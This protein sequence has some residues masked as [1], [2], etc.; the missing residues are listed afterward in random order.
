MIPPVF[1]PKEDESVTRF[2]SDD[3]KPG[4]GFWTPVVRFPHDIPGD[5]F[6]ILCL[7]DS[8]WSRYAGLI[9]EWVGEHEDW[10]VLLFC[11]NGVPESNIPIPAEP[12]VELV[13]PNASQITRAL[14]RLSKILQQQREL[15]T[16]ELLLRKQSRNLWILHEVGKALGAEHDLHH[17]LDLILTHARRITGADAGSIYILRVETPNGITSDPQ[18]E[19]K[20][21][22]FF[23]HTQSDTLDLPHRGANIEVNPNSMSGFVAL[24]GQVLNIPD[25]Y[26]LPPDTPYKHNRAFDRKVGYRTVSLLTLPMRDADDQI[27]GVL[28]LINKKRHP[29]VALRPIERVETEVI[30]FAKEDENLGIAVAGQAAVALENG[31]LYESIERLFEGFIRA[32]VKAIESRDPTTSG[33]SERVAMLTLAQAE[34]VNAVSTGPF[35]DLKFTGEQLR[36][37]RYAGLLHDFG[38][39]GVREQVLQKAHRLYPGDWKNLE[40]RIA[41]AKRTVQFLDT[42]RRIEILQKDGMEAYLGQSETMDTSLTQRLNELDE[43]RDK[44]WAVNTSGSISDEDLAEIERIASYRFPDFQGDLQPLLT[45]D[46]TLNFSIRH[47]NLNHEERLEMQSHVTDSFEFLKNIPWTRNLLNVPE[48]AFGHHERPAGDGYPRGIT[49]EQLLL[50]SKMMAIADIFDA[51]T[52]SDRPYKPAMPVAKALNILRQEAEKGGLDKDLVELFNEAKIYKKVR[53][54]G[55]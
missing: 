18:A 54:S 31:L 12:N 13:S 52:S 7:S 37:I 44:L 27:I 42:C 20:R 51:L 8:T 9:R 53:H 1:Y 38:K 28:Q 41:L 43:V 35:R 45:S 3:A 25:A 23:A 36:E 5:D 22:L 50:Q 21:F 40:T 16:T 2:L 26:A 30:P 19:G 48:I 34:A 46:E 14:H 49:G 6:G 15:R 17:L 39:I 55:G 33:H 11:P 10:G 24:T 29:E 4:I 32:S 47:G